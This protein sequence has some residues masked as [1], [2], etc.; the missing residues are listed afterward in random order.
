MTALVELTLAK[1]P[2]SFTLLVGVDPKV[3]PS[4]SPD[5]THTFFLGECALSTGGDLRE[6]RNEMLLKGVDNFLGG[7]PPYEPALVKLEDILIKMG[8]L[9]EQEL[10]DKAKEYQ[11]RF[12]DYY[13]MHDS[14]WDPEY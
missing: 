7:C 11:K 9:K 8:Y 2:H 4:F 3:P 14:T 5:L 6:L 12:F 13:R 10:I 1:A